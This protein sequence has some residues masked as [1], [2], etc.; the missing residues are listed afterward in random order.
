MLDV[1]RAN[2]CGEPGRQREPVTYSQSAGPAPPVTPSPASV[3]ERP[4]SAIVLIAVLSVLTLALAILGNGN[5]GLALAPA[6][7]FLV[8]YTIA[9]VPLRYPWL[10]YIA[11]VMSLDTPA[12]PFA[13]GEYNSPLRPIAVALSSQLKNVIPSGA[14]VM[15]GL[16]L[17]I[18]GT[19]LVHAI[20]R[21]KASP[22]DRDGY[23]PTPLPLSV[24]SWLCLV[25]VMLATVY[26]IATG[27]QFRWA[28]WQIQR[29]MYLPLVFLL[30]QAVFPS[31]S[32]MRPYLKLL[33]AIACL[34]SVLAIWL[35]FDYPEVEY[36]S[37]HS[38]SM[39]FGTV[40]CFLLIRLLHGATRREKWLT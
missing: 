33:V 7:G 26:G 37:S 35:R 28:L 16:D 15:S 5:I 20:R 21:A 19:L 22:L 30:S 6:L 13:S 11:L 18:M 24:A 17:L 3:S 39:L 8:L 1:G 14:L 27:G 36:T 38:D 29:N 25:A 9:K 4:T 23:V 2:L 12:E 31:P 34:R 10:V 40:T 32:N